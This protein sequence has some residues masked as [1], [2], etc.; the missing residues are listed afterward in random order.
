MLAS[1]NTGE[2][3]QLLLCRWYIN[4]MYLA[5]EDIRTYA[6][7]QQDAKKYYTTL[8]KA[9]NSYYTM[10]NRVRTS[11]VGDPFEYIPK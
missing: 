1:E 5:I 3:K 11:K 10:M 4:E 6:T 9:M 7:N 8:I 2:K